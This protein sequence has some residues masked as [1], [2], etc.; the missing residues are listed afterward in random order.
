MTTYIL[1]HWVGNIPFALLG[2]C[3]SETTIGTREM[4]IYKIQLTGDE[5]VRLS[6]EYDVMIRTIG[7]SKF[8][9]L[10]DLGGGFKGR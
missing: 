3:T 7:S 9:Y 10:D 5:I 8:L 2:K 1:R 6:E 4:T